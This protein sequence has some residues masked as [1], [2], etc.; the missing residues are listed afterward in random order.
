MED[1][2]LQETATE[3]RQ[4]VKVGAMRYVLGIGLA[5]ALVGMLVAWLF[6]SR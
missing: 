2:P 1:R 5:G 6:L 3:A 4:S